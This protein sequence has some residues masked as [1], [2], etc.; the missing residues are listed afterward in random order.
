MAVSFLHISDMH[1]LRDY[2][3]KGKEYGKIVSSMQNPFMQLKQLLK[4]VREDYQFVVIS[5][6]IC[7]YGEDGDYASFRRKIRNCFPDKPI[8]IT[9]GNHDIKKNFCRGYLKA[10]PHD[11]LFTDEIAEGIR[12]I[13]LDSSSGDHPSGMITEKSCDLLENALRIKTGLPTFVVTHH[14]LLA[15]QFS[16]PKAE[17]PARL[18]KIVRNSEIS[19][20]LT[21]HTHHSYQ[22][23][24]AGKP[25]YTSGSLSFLADTTPDGCLTF[26]QHPSLNAFTIEGNEISLSVYECKKKDRILDKWKI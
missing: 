26:F 3:G 17:Y 21:G 7:E 13:M 19:A 24:F 8:L 23:E 9:T 10:E 12:V 2:T 18:E 6:D 16:M 1:Y 15:D 25:Y 5:G 11:P 4:D 14:H 22:S 20:V